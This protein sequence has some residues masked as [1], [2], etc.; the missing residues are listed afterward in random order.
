MKESCP[1]ALEIIKDSEEITEEIVLHYNTLGMQNREAKNFAE[2]VKNYSKAISVSPQDENLHYNI[3]RAYFEEGKRDKA[4][5]YLEKALK[6]N[7]EF[8]EG[9]EFFEYL[10][11]LDQAKA[12]NSSDSGKKSGGLF[13]KLFSA[14]K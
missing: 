7:P 14:K 1:Q 2:A 10:L 6:L 3:A 8:K 11:K 12:D 5:D 13:Q 4:E 9:K